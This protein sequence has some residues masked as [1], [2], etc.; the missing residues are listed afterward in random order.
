MRES[1]GSLRWCRLTGCLTRAQIELAEIAV[2]QQV[3]HTISGF[4]CEVVLL[5]PDFRA[6]DVAFVLPRFAIAGCD[7]AIAEASQAKSL[8]PSK[9]GV[10]LTVEMP[11]SGAKISALLTARQLATMTRFHLARQQLLSAKKALEWI[12]TAAYPSRRPAAPFDDI[13]D[14]PKVRTQEDAPRERELMWWCCLDVGLQELVRRSLSS[15]PLTKA[16][17][18]GRVSDPVA[19][20]GFTDTVVG[21]SVAKFASDANLDLECMKAALLHLHSRFYEEAG[22]IC[23]TFVLET[24]DPLTCTRKANTYG[25][26]KM[27]K[28]CVMG[29]LQL[30][31]QRWG[32]FFL[33][34]ARSKCFLF[35]SAVSEFD[36]HRERVQEL[37]AG[38]NVV[39]VTFACSSCP[40]AT[41]V[42]TSQSGVFALLFLELFV[43]KVSWEQIPFD[44]VAYFRLRYLMQSIRVLNCQDIHDIAAF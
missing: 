16:I 3:P 2:M 14:Y 13:F 35:Q 33:D 27:K 21:A 39:G 23:P 5:S 44:A 25:A 1:A 24:A 15:M 26:F 20:L 40:T 7:D 12:E 37:L 22:I 38:F 19:V 4:V 17:I 32:S 11:T 6:D 42:P 41:P 18:R 34:C 10:K 29:V 36:E 28:Q 9:L 30:K 8:P 43:L 31:S